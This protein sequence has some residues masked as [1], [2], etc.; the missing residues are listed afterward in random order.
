MTEVI[1]DELPAE[2]LVPGGQLHRRVR[3]ILTEDGIAVYQEAQPGGPIELVFRSR[4]VTNPADIARPDPRAPRRRR[5]YKFET[6]HGPVV[7]NAVAGCLCIFPAL[8]GHT[9]DSL[10]D[11]VRVGSIKT[12]AV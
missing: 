3:A 10:R 2:V 5:A 11:A 7:M 8:R 9:L 4:L 1:A 6:D 12:T